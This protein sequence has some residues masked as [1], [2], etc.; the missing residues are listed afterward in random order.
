MQSIVVV[1]LDA[2]HFEPLQMHKALAVYSSVAVLIDQQGD[3]IPS[4]AQ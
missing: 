2:K 4:E 1:P 3:Q